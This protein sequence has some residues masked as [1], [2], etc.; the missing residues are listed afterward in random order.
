MENLINLIICYIS[1][2]CET[3]EVTVEDVVKHINH[4]RYS[5]CYNRKTYRKS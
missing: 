1:D 2:D 3:K 5:E 4:I